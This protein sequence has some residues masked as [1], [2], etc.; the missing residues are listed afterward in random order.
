M[1]RWQGLSADHLEWLSEQGVR[2]LASAGTAAALLPAAFYFL[3]ETRVPPIA[4]LRAAGVPM[5]VATDCNPGTAPLCSLLTAL[6]MACTL[7]RLTPSE[8]LRGA[9]HVAARVP[10]LHDRGRLA[11]GQRADLAIW[12]LE[13]P[14]GPR[15]TGRPESIAMHVHCRS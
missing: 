13:H 14:A 10:G 11:V 1:A 4:A 7:F 9:T 12:N 5:A 2:A 3:R 6:N 15:G 8:A